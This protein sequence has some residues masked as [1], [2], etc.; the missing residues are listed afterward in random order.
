MDRRQ[1]NDG[2]RPRTTV[3]R[4]LA[5]LSVAKPER[6][7]EAVKT[8]ATFEENTKVEEKPEEENSEDEGGETTPNNDNTL[9]LE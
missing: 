9:G 4:Q 5:G 6:Q 1:L 7:L 8:N 2:I 3:Q